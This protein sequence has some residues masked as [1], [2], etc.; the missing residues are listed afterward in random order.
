[1]I[2]KNKCKKDFK[3]KKSIQLC[4]RIAPSVSR[5]LKK[6]GLSPTGI[7]YESLKEL[8]LI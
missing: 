4:I 1:M 2:D 6:Q 3:E 5:E 7:F 8:K